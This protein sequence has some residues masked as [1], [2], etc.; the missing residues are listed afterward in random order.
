MIILVD[1]GNSA[2]T[3]GVY[4]GDGCR[5]RFFTNT[6]IR[7][8]A[9]EYQLII[10]SFLKTIVDPF[11]HCDAVVLCSVVPPLTPVIQTALQTLID[12]P[13]MTLGKKIKTGIALHVDHPSEVGADL[14][15]ASVAGIARYKAPLVIADLGTASKI[16]ALDATGAFVGVTIAPGLMVAHQGLIGRASQLAEVDLQIPKQV[17]GRNTTDAVNSGA[18]YGHAAMVRGLATKV[19]QELQTTKPVIL[20]GGYAK[21]IRQLLPDFIYD[22]NLLLDGLLQIYHKNRG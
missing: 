7:K 4:D 19:Q 2:L 13:L 22:E 15:A 11:L 14:V 1:L 21:L 12:A 3:I 16:I 6:D 10:A 9:I 18:L 17:I 5:H 8:T 20:T